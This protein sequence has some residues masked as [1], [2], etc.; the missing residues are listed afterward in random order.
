MDGINVKS[1]GLSFS[2]I[3]L[4]VIDNRVKKS[5]NENIDHIMNTMNIIAISIV[6]GN[7]FRANMIWA[8]VKR[9]LIKL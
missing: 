6:L 4:N 2:I 7:I 5:I 3:Y 8:N 1:N 9:L